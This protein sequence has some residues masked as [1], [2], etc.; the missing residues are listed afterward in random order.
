[1]RENNVGEV[2]RGNNVGED[3]HP[4]FPSSIFLFLF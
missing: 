4:C 2:M 1:M 3:S